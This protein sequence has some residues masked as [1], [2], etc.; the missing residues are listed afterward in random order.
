M[1]KAESAERYV[2]QPS[3]VYPAGGEMRTR[4]HGMSAPHMS[5]I[6]KTSSISPASKSNKYS[7]QLVNVP[8][9]CSNLTPI[10]SRGMARWA[11]T[12]K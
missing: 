2:P 6:D 7:V 5:G 12:S 8:A 10:S 1:A 11:V 4:T 9:A 3:Q